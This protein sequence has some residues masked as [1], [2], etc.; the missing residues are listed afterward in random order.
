MFL[1]AQG[2][3]LADGDALHAALAGVGVDGDGEE[4]AAAVGLFLQV[5][6]VGLGQGKLEVAEGIHQQAELFL[7][8]LALCAFQS[9]GGDGFENRL[10]QQV[11]HVTLVSGRITKFTQ[12]LL[13]VA[14]LA[15]QVGG[16][17]AAG[18]DAPDSSFEHLGGGV[19]QTGDRRVG[20]DGV[21][22][23]AGGAVFRD[24]L[25]VLETDVGHVAVQTGGGRNDRQCLE[26]I[27]Q[28]VR[29]LAAGVEGAGLLP[30]TVHVGH[31]AVVLRQLF[32]H[33]RQGAV[34]LLHLLTSEAY[35][36]VLDLPGF[37]EA[38]AYHAQ[39]VLHHAFALGAE[40]G[41]ELAFDGSEELLLVQPCH[42]HQGRAGEEGA[43]EGVALHA[44]LQL[45]VARL[46]AGDL[47]AVD[48]EHANLVID[49]ELLSLP[50]EAGPQL[51]FVVVGR[52]DNKNA[53]LFQ[54]VNRVGVTK[55]IRIRAHD[56]I[57]VVILAVDTDAL[58]R[59]GKVIGGRLALLLRA[60]LGIGLDIK[61]KQ[62][63]EGHRQVLAGG[64]GAPAA[65]RVHAHSD[66]FFR[67]QVRVFRTAQ[68]QIAHLRV[69]LQEF[70]NM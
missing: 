42:F 60:V 30:E 19:D 34:L 29:A 2:I 11:A 31:P 21:A 57:N 35:D 23:A 24:P 56:H 22:V 16:D 20:A 51:L 70:L 28:V 59:G 66:R 1:C 53:A 39:V 15:T 36:L 17:G 32:Q 48:V 47:E 13:R 49:D 46:F 55:H 26:G 6:P 64:D 7:Q 4:T 38:A 10:V 65:N 68:R 67:H 25:R 50:R 40:L 37:I 58:R 61:A 43:L 52:L 54:A 8:L 41:V 45:R 3:V 63:V 14:G 12:P 27:G 18:F 33:D 69:S 5:V 62:L 9:G 44:Q